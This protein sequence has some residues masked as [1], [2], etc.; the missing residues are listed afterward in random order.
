MNT[1]YKLLATA[2]LAVTTNNFV[3]FA[4]TFW[5][6]LS[7][8]S[9]IATSTLGGLYLVIT[10]V[11]SIWFG[12]VVD[13]H[14]KKDALLASSGASLVLFAAGWIFLR[15]TPAAA[16]ASVGSVRLWIFATLLLCGTIAGTIYN[17]AIPTLVGL[18]VPED[19]RDRANGLFGTT[20]GIAFGITS[21][22]S[23]LVLGFWGMEAALAIAVAASAVSIVALSMIRVDE[24]VI[25]HG[26]AHPRKVDLRGTL[27]VVRSIPGLFALIFFTTF[28]NF[29]GGVFFALMDAYGLTLVSVQVWGTLWGFLSLGIIGGGL[30]ISRRGLGPDPLRTLFRVNFAIWTA[31]IFFTIQPSIVLLAFGTLVWM[32]SFPFIEAI[33]QTVLQKVVPPERLGRV[34]GFAHSIEQSAS[35]VTA[36]F[37]GPVAQLV[38]IPFMTTGKGVE[39]IGRWFGVGMGRG[40]A[41][42]FTTAGL[43][44]VTVTAL[45][46]RSRAY[47]V[48]ADRYTQ[49][50]RQS[51]DET[52]DDPSMVS[53]S[54]MAVE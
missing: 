36:F 47:R 26:E 32:F 51:V 37:I 10:A 7:T 29:L 27:R 46:R 53:T 41:L 22:G 14:R 48:L 18:T 1:F 33:E 28:N 40:I 34:I 38:F 54:A 3:W 49:S 50:D 35:P 2:L 8:R 11:S 5:A 12:S 25:T 6:F 39:L 44:G 17:I 42:L 19:R 4:L 43:V 20:I 21:V 30:F 45:A 13:H 52:T 16:F 9:V 23:G 15:I 24:P 31:C